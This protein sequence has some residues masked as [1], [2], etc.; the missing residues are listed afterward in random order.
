M[1]NES[2]Q[3]IKPIFA[4]TPGERILAMGNQAIA[5]GAIEAGVQ[6]ASG[7]PG[8]PSTE[9]METLIAGSSIFG[10]QAFWGVNEK[11][12]FDAASGASFAGARA[13]VAVKHVGVNVLSDSLM[14]INHIDLAGGLVLV[15]VDDVGGM[16]SN[17][18][19]DSRFYADFA[20]IPCLEPATL[21][22][23]REMVKAAFD[24]SENLG[25]PVMVRS[26]NRLSHLTSSMVLGEIPEARQAPRFDNS[27]RW[28]GFPSLEP[29]RK[30][31]EKIKHA[32]QV[33]EPYGYNRLNLHPE[34]R[35]A[36]IAGGF[37]ANYA[38]E[39]LK[40][41]GLSGQI[42]FLQVR[43]TNPLPKELFHQVIAH[44][45][46]II[47]AEDVNWYLENAVLAA[48]ADSGRQPRVLGRK[49][50]DLPPVGETTADNLAGVLEKL[51]PG[52]SR[53]PGIQ[54][55]LIDVANEIRAEIPNRGI[56]FCPGCPHRGSFYSLTKAVKSLDLEKDMAVVGDIGCYTL[57]IWEPFNLL[58]SM[59]SMGAS[60]GTATA[61]AQLSPD[62]KTLAVI[63]DST[64]FHA[65]QPGLLQIALN[66]SPVTV[67]VT[68]NRVTAMTGAQ[69]DASTGL[70]LR[71]G[72]DHSIKIENLARAYGFK[73]I[74]IGDAYNIPQMFSLYRKALRINGP[75]MVIA[76]RECALAEQ[77][78]PLIRTKAKVIA[79]KCTG[80]MECIDNF[81]CP[82]LQIRES[83]STESGKKVFVDLNACVGCGECKYACPD[84]AIT[85]DL[86]A[87]ARS[88]HEN[89]RHIFTASFR[90]IR[91]NYWKFKPT[92]SFKKKLRTLL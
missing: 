63:G 56:N 25:V 23:A 82:A 33:L 44:A 12:A 84:N 49:S 50:G 77:T 19:Q 81:G 75:S 36:I 3:L 88:I 43:T 86:P 66:Q 13:L 24:V 20:E 70:D 74:F 76:R 72:T 31:R 85:L 54:N 18:E 64:L 38:A 47:V 69:A 15:A 4:D 42:S 90:T 29:H 68:D 80:C 22:E 62:Q 7:Y 9:I 37:T 16:S 45:D 6:L 17:N 5:R 14:Q 28:V 1:P 71:G 21:D 59:T 34:S 78:A 83:V 2:G 60:M 46:N 10:Y 65:G 57:G 30:L 32:G 53:L 11:V 61:I 92:W 55:N 35:V 79:K 48:I 27:H 26:V 39:A 52:S 41:T 87:L 73:H 89:R 51:L 67:V 40:M 91:K 58:K 8:T